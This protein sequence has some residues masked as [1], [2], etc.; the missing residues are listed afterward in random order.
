M[1][2]LSLTKKPVNA[3]KKEITLDDKK[4]NIGLPLLARCNHTMVTKCTKTT[5]VF[6][7]TSILEQK[8]YVFGGLVNNEHQ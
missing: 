3:V 8:S 4:E 2:R 5:Q 1:R 7:G 6:D